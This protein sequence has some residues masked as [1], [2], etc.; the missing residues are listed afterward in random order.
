MPKKELNS[1]LHAH[2]VSLRVHLLLML[3]LNRNP[4]KR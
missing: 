1:S 2:A 4:R 3:V